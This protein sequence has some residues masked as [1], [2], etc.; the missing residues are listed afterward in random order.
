M[1]TTQLYY[2]M[3]KNHFYDEI[4]KNDSD[5]LKKE[6]AHRNAEYFFRIFFPEFKIKENRFK[7][8]LL[9]SATPNNKA[10]QLYK[11]IVDIF[12]KIHIE[13]VEPFKLVL[14]EINDLFQFL[15]SNVLPK[16]NLKYKKI[17]KKRGLF[18]NE[19]QS[20]REELEKYLETVVKIAKDKAIEPI[21]LYIN[22]IVDFINMEIYEMDYHES[23]GILIFYILMVENNFKASSY[24]SFFQ[25]LNLFKADYQDIFTKVKIQSKQGVPDLMPLMMF[26][27]NL[28]NS[29]YVDLGL[30]ARDKQFDKETPINKTDFIENTIYKLPDVFSKE[31]IRFRHPSFS[32]STINRTLKRLQEENIIR[33]IGVGRSAKWVK[34]IKQDSKA[35][36]EGQIKMNLGE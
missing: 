24:I 1:T 36:F 8:L 30:V 15:F 11:N 19:T 26:F 20:M 6:V 12:C 32:D 33:A 3:G 31:D 27:V 7:S 35:K 5:Y 4:L 21:F 23:L 29:M 2:E 10:E 17:G 13:D 34:I 22:F 16:E 28:F 14:T 25:K 18:V 9:A